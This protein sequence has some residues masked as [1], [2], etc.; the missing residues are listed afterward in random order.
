MF[1]TKK[2]EEPKPTYDNSLVSNLSLFL[3]S[4]REGM[5]L[6]HSCEI[7]GNEVRYISKLVAKDAHFKNEIVKALRGANTDLILASSD[8]MKKN[9]ADKAMEARKM[10][11]R[12]AKLITWEC[13]AKHNE[14]DDKKFI[15]TYLEIR[16]KKDTATALG[17]TFEEYND[18]LIDNP[19]VV[20]II[21]NLI[22]KDE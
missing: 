18:Y 21:D 1:K 17:L 13:V 6:T 20:E 15:R 8:F 16:D 4:I 2:K 7:T 14:W 3:L 22:G 9:Q 11:R 19:E 5:G 12:S 10:A